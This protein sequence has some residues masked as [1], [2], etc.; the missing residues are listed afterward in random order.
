VNGTVVQDVNIT[1]KKKW[2]K[3]STLKAGTKN[4]KYTPLVEASKILLPPLHM[5]NFVINQD[6]AAF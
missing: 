4:V 1:L 6:G 5:K 3:R 2:L